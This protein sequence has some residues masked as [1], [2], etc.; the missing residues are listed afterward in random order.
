MTHEE[1]LYFANL[2]D[3]VW[4]KVASRQRWTDDTD[5]NEHIYIDI[6]PYK[7]FADVIDSVL[8]FSDGTVEF[9]MKLEE[10]A[11]NWCEFPID[12]IRDVL[13][14]TLK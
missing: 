3:E 10:D 7:F 2:W 11:Y 5:P 6:E 8:I 4:A 13:K 14:L 9:H 1:F 12:V